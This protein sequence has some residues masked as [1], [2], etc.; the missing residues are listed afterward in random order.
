ML[1]LLCLRGYRMRGPGSSKS[2]NKS[3]ITSPSH[4][5]WATAS[6]KSK[7]R[8]RR[9]SNAG[10][11]SALK[12]CAGILGSKMHRTATSRTLLTSSS[13]SMRPSRGRTRAL[14]TAR[15]PWT[16]SL[17][18]SR[19]F[20]FAA[21][22]PDF[23]M[24]TFAKNCRKSRIVSEQNAT[25]VS[26]VSSVRI[27]F[28][29]SSA[30]MMVIASSAHDKPVWIPGVS[31]GNLKPRGG[32]TVLLRFFLVGATA[33][34]APPRRSSIIVLHAA[35]CVRI[36]SSKSP[37]F[38]FSD[39]KSCPLSNACDKLSTSLFSQ[40]PSLIFTVHSPIASEGSSTGTTSAMS[41]SVL[42][43]TF[44]FCLFFFGSDEDLLASVID[45][46]GVSSFVPP[47]CTNFSLRGFG[48]S[49]VISTS[50]F[51]IPLL[52]G[53]DNLNSVSAA[54][55]LWCKDAISS[56]EGIRASAFESLGRILVT[57]LYRC[58]CD[59]TVVCS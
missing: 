7:N 14:R 33:G 54:P 1:S 27:S 42:S 41:I 46:C 40:S 25:T 28:G 24:S 21:L 51:G 47:S 12:S 45:T 16:I 9:T 58:V 43:G 55:S 20:L 34:C 30:D 38:S 29:A 23:G 22:V 32:S 10:C 6:G 48:S 2:H 53:L 57:S 36:C 49:I 44:F 15:R 39:L 19:P 17:Q 4:R 52:V 11:T 59:G 26:K 8:A 31:Q 35:T 37:N 13:L 5:S 56:P 3:W 50:G 18:G